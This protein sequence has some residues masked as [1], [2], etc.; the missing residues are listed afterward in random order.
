MARLGV[1]IMALYLAS[2]SSMVKHSNKVLSDYM[3]DEHELVDV[4]NHGE[5]NDRDPYM[6]TVME[7]ATRSLEGTT[8]AWP[9]LKNRT[10]INVSM[11]ITLRWSP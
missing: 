6:S 2:K 9:C 1:K 7:G 3:R 8:R 4:L 11:W 5:I 10:A